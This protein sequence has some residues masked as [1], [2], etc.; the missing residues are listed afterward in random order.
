MKEKESSGL[1]RFFNLEAYESRLAFILIAPTV[2]AV[3]VVLFFPLAY[4]FSKL[5]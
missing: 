1:K 3:L 4:S 2:I 5:Y